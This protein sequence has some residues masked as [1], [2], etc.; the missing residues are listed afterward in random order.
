[1]EPAATFHALTMADLEGVLEIERLSFKTPWSRLAFIHEM[2]FE[3]SVFK[4]VRL[5]GRLIGY[6]G[7]WHLHNEAHISN[8]AIHPDYQKEGFGRKLLIHLLEEAVTRG[9]RKASLEVRRSN[10]EAQKL[11]GAFGFAIIGVKKHYYA[12]ENEDALVMW[13]AD[14]A[15]TLEALRQGRLQGKA[16]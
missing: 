3:Q 12:D 9:V 5:G 6:G 8:I 15:G 7:F 13:N 10:V 14:I 16:T 4:V 2:Q 1:M 11:Y